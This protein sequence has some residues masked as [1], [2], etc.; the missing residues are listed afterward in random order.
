[1]R[2]TGVAGPGMAFLVRHPK[3][4]RLDVYS[5]AVDDSGVGHLIGCR[6]LTDIGLSMTGITNA[7]FE[8][9]GKLPI[10]SDADLTANLLITTDAVCWPSKKLIHSVILNGTK[11]DHKRA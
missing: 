3:L 9:L 1:M 5:T 6:S 7:V 11:S 8:H 10:L 2:G 4:R